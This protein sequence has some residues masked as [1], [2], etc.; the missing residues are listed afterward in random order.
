MKTK[1]VLLLSIAFAFYLSS[2]SSNDNSTNPNPPGNGDYYKLKTGNYWVFNS[3]STD[4]ETNEVTTTRDSS[5]IVGQ[6]TIAGKEAFKYQTYSDGE[7]EGFNYE[8]SENGSLYVLLKSL[9]PEDGMLPDLGS[10]LDNIWVK[11]A[12]PNATA[13]WT[14]Y[15]LDLTDIPLEFEGTQ[16]KFSGNLTFEGLKGDKVIVPVMGKDQTAQKYTM[17]AVIKLSTK[18]QG[19]PVPVEFT[20]PTN[21]F[22]VDGIG[23]VKTTTESATVNLMV[24]TIKTPSSESNL[25]N[26]KVN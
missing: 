9:L 17:N 18:I 24:T 6:E 8:Y 10:S 20:V 15:S 23:L 12:D 5:I 19:I 16:L 7:D 1:I 21:F 4:P 26:Y 3:A 11:V 25:I 14:I 2:C 22:Y 13:K